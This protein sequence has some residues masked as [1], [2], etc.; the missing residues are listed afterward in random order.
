M[1]LSGSI[2][3]ASDKEGEFGSF[4]VLCFRHLREKQ[5]KE[6]ERGLV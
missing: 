3:Y 6:G 2:E 5:I 4:L 1:E